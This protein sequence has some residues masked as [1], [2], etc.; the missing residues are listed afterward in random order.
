MDQGMKRLFLISLFLL[1]PR[2]IFAQYS[3]YDGVTIGPTSKVINQQS[4][5]V[6]SQPADVF[7][8]PCSPQ[9]TIYSSS[10]GAAHANPVSS[11]Q[12]GN[13]DP[14]PPARV[15]TVPTH[16]PQ[17]QT[18]FAR[19]D[20]S[21][22]SGV[23]HTTDGIQYVS[24][25]GSDSNDGLSWETA[26]ATLSGAYSALPTCTH[27][28]PF[29]GG[30]GNI[31]EPCGLIILGAGTYSLSSTLTIKSLSVRIKGPFIGSAAIN[32][33]AATCI[34]FDP[35]N[36]GSTFDGHPIQNSYGMEHVL[37]T[38]NGSANQIGFKCIDCIG[39]TTDHLQIANFTGSGATAMDLEVDNRT[40]HFAEIQFHTA[41]ALSNNTNGI[42]FNGPPNAGDFDYSRFLHITWIIQQNQTLLTMTGIAHC[43]RCRFSGDSHQIGTFSNEFGTN[44]A[45]GTQLFAVW[46]VK[47]D[48]SLPNTGAG[49][50]Q[51]LLFADN[52]GVTNGGGFAGIG[53][54]IALEGPSWPV[55]AAPPQLGGGSFTSGWK[56]TFYEGNEAVGNDANGILAKQNRWF[57]FL[58]GS[59]AAGD[60]SSSAPDTNAGVSIGGNGTVTYHEQAAPP[61]P[62]ST[63]DSCYGDST[64]HALKC[65]YN[66]GSFLNVPQVIASGTATMTTAAITAGN[67][68]ATVTVAAAGVAA[69]DSITW[70]FNS[71]PAGSNAGIVAWPTSGGVNFAYCPGVAETPVAATINWRV[72]R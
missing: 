48:A 22:G 64:A 21:V 47:Y 7:T 9:A 39:V 25:G 3:R 70:A 31:T 52:M 43:N 65:S 61:T 51:P 68:G 60:S 26:R 16:G 44:L 11:D 13:N 12:F 38:G 50:F 35:F 20:T 18:P 28:T 57:S 14:Y 53:S 67:C 4:I 63:F 41:L 10:S 15:Y 19:T 8:Q 24:T 59:N 2:A 45:A 33:T 55:T 71:A 56:M 6:C 46:D 29:S 69:T 40:G 27:H 1:V 32:C 5:A 17:I 42:L 23:N 62:T 30:L 58:G 49:N 37:I 72:V 34:V 66:N 54:T 36:G